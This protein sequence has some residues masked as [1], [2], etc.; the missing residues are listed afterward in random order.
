[1]KSQPMTMAANRHVDAHQALDVFRGNIRYLCTPS[2]CM[3]FKPREP[4][5]VIDDL[6][7]SADG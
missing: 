2:T 5:F 1:M 3:Q 6:R 7:G 4:G